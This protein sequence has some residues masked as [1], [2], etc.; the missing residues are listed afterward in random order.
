MVAHQPL[1]LTTAMGKL[2]VF[3][4]SA[5]DTVAVTSHE[6]VT[7]FPGETVASLLYFS[8]GSIIYILVFCLLSTQSGIRGIVFY[9]AGPVG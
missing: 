7:F 1:P 5:K 8:L 9:P 2:S 3:L 6:Q 4:S